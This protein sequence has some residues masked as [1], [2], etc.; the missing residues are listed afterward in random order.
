MI[1]MILAAGLGTRLRPLTDHLP[2]PAL[3]VANRPLAAFALERLR[4]AG[5]R[6][7]RANGHHLADAME[8]TLRALEPAI[9]FFAEPVLLGTGGGLRNALADVD[10]EVVVMNGDVLFDIDL[11]RVIALH[12]AHDAFATMVLRTDPNAIAMGAVYVDAEMRVASIAGYPSIVTGAPYAFSGVHVL[13][14]RVLRALPE[15]GCIVRKGYH[16]FLDAG[17]RVLG[18][19]DDG[20]WADLGT[21]AAYLAANVALANGSWSWPGIAP[22]ARGIVAS[23]LPNA[24]ISESVVGAGVTA[25]PGL[26]IERSVVL[27]GSEL[28][29]DA[30]GAIVTPFD[31]IVP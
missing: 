21:H 29:E 26:R 7:V 31:R 30:M 13:S 16:R 8:A 28:R 11:A 3:P 19:V 20:R 5:V 12:R 14:P 24:H 15:E 25:S 6:E 9:R 22:D 10:E 1:G 2:K 17:E 4:A 23:A 27:P 18:V